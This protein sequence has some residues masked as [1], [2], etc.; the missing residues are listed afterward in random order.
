M[1]APPAVGDIYN[2]QVQWTPQTTLVDKSQFGMLISTDPLN[3]RYVFNRLLAAGAGIDLSVG[4]ILIVYGIDFG[5]IAS[6]TIAGP[7]VTV[8]LGP[9]TLGDAISDGVIDWDFAV[10]LSAARVQFVSPSGTIL[11]AQAPGSAQAAAA[12]PVV[13]KFKHGNFDYEITASLIGTA[14]DLGITIKKD[15]VAPIGATFSVQAHLESYRAKNR[16]EVAGGQLQS[17]N[18]STNGLKGDATLKLVVAGSG[19]DLKYEPRFTV[20]KVPFLIGP[21][22]ASVNIGLMVVVNA[23][24]PIEG[25]AGVETKFTYDSDLGLSYGGTTANLSANL[26]G[27]TIGDPPAQPYAAAAS[28]MAANFGV[29]F[30]EIGLAVGAGLEAGVWFRPGFLIGASFTGSPIPN[31]VLADA[32]FLG[33]VGYDVSVWGFES[34]LLSGSK[35]VFSFTKPL[36][37]FGVCPP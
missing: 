12:Q 30:P 27:H 7:T 34:N 16:F 11:A 8:T 32:L 36:G 29:G 17:W 31:C 22:P 10:P 6:S 24:V 14:A 1:I 23:V 33:A 20:M 35:S 4:R 21:I 19:T 15:L 9:A 13:I 25:S 3:R 26:L 5:R 18:S 2:V 28:Q 37:K